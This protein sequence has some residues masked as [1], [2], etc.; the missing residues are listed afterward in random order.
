M[1]RSDLWLYHIELKTNRTRGSSPA[2]KKKIGT[3]HS[4]KEKEQFYSLRRCVSLFTNKRDIR[5]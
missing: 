5:S 4:I 2:P 3:S 1:C